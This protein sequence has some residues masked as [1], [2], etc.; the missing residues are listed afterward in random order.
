M[1]YRLRNIVVA[2]GLAVVA[3]LSDD[4]L[5]RELQAPRPPGRKHRSRCTWRRR[6]SPRHAWRRARSSVSWL[7]TT[8]VAAAHRRARRDLEP[9]PGRALLTT[10]TIYAGE[11]VTLR[12]FA[13]QRRA[14]ASA[15]SCTAPLRALSLPGTD[16]QLLAGTL[17]DGDHVDVIANLKTGSLRRRCF[18]VRDVV[19]EPAR[20]ARARGTEPGA[21]K[22]GQTARP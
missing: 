13:S 10:Q 19:A 4:V 22:V 6:T 3:A 17:K 2:V 9:R 12:R 8:D 21:V 16:D 14:S 5:R 15:R 20:P 1:T 7:T 18:A 11:Q